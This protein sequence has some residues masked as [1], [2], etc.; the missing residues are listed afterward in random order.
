MPL[1]KELRQN[2]VHKYYEGGHMFYLNRAAHEA[3]KKDVVE[4]YEAALTK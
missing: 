1:N 2:I 3:L 4:F